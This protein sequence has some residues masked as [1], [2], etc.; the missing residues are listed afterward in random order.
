MALVA[1]SM[2]LSGCGH[3]SEPA[4]K[5]AA[6]ATKAD[7]QPIRIERRDITMHVDQPGTIQAFES[8]PIFARIGGYVDKYRVN[9][10]DRVKAGDVL[11]GM[12]VPDMVEALNQ[13]K[14]ATD[15]AKVQIRVAESAARSAKAT[16][17]N[18]KARVVSAHAGV[19]RAQAGYSRWESEAKRLDQLVSEKVLNTQVRDETYRQFE[20]AAAARDQADAMVN[21]AIASLDKAKADLEGAA[22]DIEAAKADLVVAQSEQS[23]AQ[24]MLDYGQIK[25]PYDGV[26]TQRNVSPGDY[27]QAGGGTGGRPLFVLEQTDPVRVFVGVPE[28]AAGFIKDQ[29]TALIRIQAVPGAFRRGKIVRSGF[30]LNPSSR[31]LQTEIDIPNEDGNLRPGMYVTATITIDR[32]QVFAVPSS[33]V[34]FLGGQSYALD[35]LIDGKTVR[36]PVLIGPSDDRFTE[37]LRKKAKADQGEDWITPDGTE[38][39]ASTDAAGSGSTR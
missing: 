6:S 12:W 17:E 10:G 16:L 19:K 28:L 14:A 27:L 20:E 36:T 13:K 30:S 31:T 25:A 3:K 18:F 29:D 24:V 26:I 15:R 1:G 38:L 39:L 8:T 4:G 32:K 34:V 22:V 11:L 9:I 21:E 23:Q 33:S 7:S 2:F 37:I 5:E 35:L